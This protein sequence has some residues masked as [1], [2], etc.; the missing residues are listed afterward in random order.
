MKQLLIFLFA[1]F[2]I[3]HTVQAAGPAP[4]KPGS[5][6]QS[7][8]KKKPVVPSK[9]QYKVMTA[10][11]NLATA[12]RNIK[13]NKKKIQNLA[14]K[15]KYAKAS[16]RTY[17]KGYNK[18]KKQLDTLLQK[19]SLTAKQKEKASAMNRDTKN[20]LSKLR[21]AKKNRA[22]LELQLEK[23]KDQLKFNQ[24]KKKKFVAESAAAKKALK[25]ERWS[26]WYKIKDKVAGFFTFGK[27]KTVAAAKPKARGVTFANP[28]SEVMVKK[29]KVKRIESVSVVLERQPLGT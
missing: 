19:S 1:S 13:N 21:T 27:S 25:R 5:T 16:E 24:G 7:A 17:E 22:N 26:T 28:I 8:S 18:V 9:A 6:A 11:T 14:N 29:G 3:T 4:K 12:T 23:S 20:L 15:V 2:L 10:K